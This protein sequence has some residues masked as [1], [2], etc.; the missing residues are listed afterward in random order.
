M[1]AV[2]RSLVIRCSDRDSD[3]TECLAGFIKDGFPVDLQDCLG[4]TALHRAIKTYNVD[5]VKRLTHQGKASLSKKDHLG[6]SALHV[7]VHSAV[8]VD[9]F[10][11]EVQGLDGRKIA[12]QILNVLLQRGARVDDRDADGKTPWSYANTKDDMWIRRLKHKHLIIGSSSTTSRGMERVRPPLPGPQR[13]ACDAFDM[14][15][16]EVYVRRKA[17]RSDDIFNL[18]M[19]PVS[20]VIY[21]GPWGVSRLLDESRSSKLMGHRVHCRWVHVPSNNEQWVYDLMLSMGIQDSS[22]GGQRHEGSRLIDR[23]MMAQARRYKYFHGQPIGAEADLGSRTNRTGLAGIAADAQGV[24]PGSNDDPDQPQRKP[25][26]KPGKTLPAAEPTMTEAEGIVIFVSEAALPRVVTP[27][28]FLTA[29]SPDAD[30]GLRNAP[31]AQVPRPII[32][33]C[34]GSHQEGPSPLGDR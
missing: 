17:G 16:A 2:K 5:A 7:A 22:M 34:P 10:A 31:P 33:R 6:K 25:G 18:E 3:I 27:R 20:D 9:A 28:A 21:G 12:T 30:F 15:L 26:S 11:L 14:I 29:P 24:V 19:A 4:R 1:D 23:Y 8:L 32:S 13:G